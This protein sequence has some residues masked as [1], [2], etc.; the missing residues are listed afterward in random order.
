MGHTV[1]RLQQQNTLRR[2]ELPKTETAAPMSKAYSQGCEEVR[3]FDIFESGL[4]PMRVPVASD[5]SRALTF[6]AHFFKGGY[7][8][9]NTS[10]AIGL[11]NASLPV[12]AATLY[13]SLDNKLKEMT[14]AGQLRAAPSDTA[15]VDYVEV[16][17]SGRYD[18]D[19]GNTYG[20]L[21]DSAASADAR[22]LIITRPTKIYRGF[23]PGASL[24]TG[25]GAFSG[26]GVHGKRK[27]REI[28]WWE[29]LGAGA[30]GFSNTTVETGILRGSGHNK[31]SDVQLNGLKNDH[32]SVEQWLEIYSETLTPGIYQFTEDVFF[33][34]TAK[35][36]ATVP[37]TRNYAISASYG[38]A[39]VTC[40][41]VE[42]KSWCNEDG[43]LILA[44]GQIT[45][46]T[47]HHT[48]AWTL[49]AFTKLAT[50]GQLS[51]WFTSRTIIAGSRRF[52]PC[53][54]ESDGESFGATATGL[55]GGSSDN[56]R[57]MPTGAVIASD[58]YTLKVQGG[59]VWFEEVKDGIL[60]GT[61]SA[62]FLLASPQVNPAVGGAAVQK[63]SAIGSPGHPDDILSQS[64]NLA[65]DV[66]YVSRFGITTLDFS[67]EG[68]VYLPK[69]VEFKG[70]RFEGQ[71]CT[72]ISAAV[73]E[74]CLYLTFSDGSLWKLWPALG[75]M[76]EV[77]LSIPATYKLHGVT[78]R[79]G[80]TYLVIVKPDGARYICP[81]AQA[82][83]PE[84]YL[85]TTAF[86]RGA[87]TRAQ[88]K[89][90][91]LTAKGLKSGQVCIEGGPWRAVPLT[92]D[93]VLDGMTGTKEFF[94]SDRPASIGRGKTVEFKFVFADDEMTEPGI[95]EAI[96]VEMEV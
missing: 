45:T 73:V 77:P 64:A 79:D 92:S 69:N 78:N 95:L 16:R 8:L 81:T 54:I 40:G 43:A 17:D 38:N 84:S 14:L 12:E 20:K 65:G 35:M 55:M 63:L 13:K 72:S 51:F 34:G 61:P 41:V 25:A 89:R 94:V 66:F 32:V 26:W 50:I 37:Y 15:A 60:I 2:G 75:A 36:F 22:T 82:R 27:H 56:G 19:R 31:L 46:P 86:G 70:R 30:E 5:E 18:T 71:I 52:G 10:T 96:G 48:G 29:T 24:G 28:G 62:E 85:R 3:G 23:Y 74:H 83:A 7:Y 57:V 39:S 21:I 49:P 47:T 58:P 67:N 4:A 42:D 90:L 59:V 53:S 1:R 88:V 6:R 11:D 91:H 76:A 93:D 9:R 33:V 80:E 87:G 68:Q 44:W